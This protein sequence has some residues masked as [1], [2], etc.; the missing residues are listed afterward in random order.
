MKLYKGDEVMLMDGIKIIQSKNVWVD[1]SFQE[2]QLEIK[3]NK[4]IKIHPYGMIRPTADY[5]ENYILPGFI[6]IHDHGCLGGDANHADFDFLSKWANYLPQEGIT[7]F[8][9]TTST[10]FFDALEES[11]RMLGAFI[12]SK[13]DGA[14][15]L[16]M[17]LEGPMISEKYRGSHNPKLLLKPNVETF[18]KWQEMSNNHI[19]MITIAPENDENYEMTK[20]CA[21]HGVVVAIGH[22]AATYQQA[23]EAVEAGA[24][25]FVHTFNGMSGLHHRE[26]GV[27][28]AAMDIEDAYAEV[29]ADGVHVDFNAVRIL[30]KAKG[31]DY[32]IAV[33]DSIWAKG[34][35]PGIYPKPDKGVNIVI[36]EHNV[37]RLETG[38]LAGS[39]NRLN[40]MVR[41][42]I[43][44]A[45]L[46]LEMAINAVTCNPAHLLGIANQYGYIKEKYIADFA[47]VDKQFN[48]LETIVDGIV[49]YSK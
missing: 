24:K 21:E 2:A 41:N 6:D 8:L 15:I 45:K 38:S 35:E 42:L 17:H 30:G 33:T 40:V 3:G 18:K 47:I 13:Y 16:G 27:V 26:P 10:A 7:R 14:K 39:T 11:Y 1:E 4:I 23:K 43:D 44:E 22:S 34:C 37:V 9:P 36:D 32:L 25:S 29:I 19:K 12:D 49:V 20:Y 5:G 28:G 46:P 31:K 48:I